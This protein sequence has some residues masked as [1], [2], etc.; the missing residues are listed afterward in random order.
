MKDTRKV[1]KWNGGKR[2]EKEERWKYR[3]QWLQTRQ[4]WRQGEQRTERLMN[5]WEEGLTEERTW[6]EPKAEYREKTSGR[7]ER[8]LERR[9]GWKK[10]RGSGKWWERLSFNQTSVTREPF[11]LKSA[12][13]F[14]S[15][16]PL[17]LLCLLAA[18]MRRL[19]ASSDCLLDFTKASMH[20]W[21][22]KMNKLQ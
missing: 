22:K 6:Q 19:M 7:D 16:S 14:A 15:S 18:C 8:R 3:K 17:S 11:T 2:H 13:D 1:R 5:T 4:E 12:G 20:L 9:I 21:L 10:K